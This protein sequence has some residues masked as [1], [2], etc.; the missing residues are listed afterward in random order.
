MRYTAAEKQEIIRLVEQSALS[1]RRTLA[2]MGIP[3]S[4]FYAW[5]DRYREGGAPALEDG[6]PA[7]QRVWNKLPGSVS[8]AIVD[9]ALAEPE[10][11]PGSWQ[12]PLSMSRSISSRKLRCIGC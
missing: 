8:E 11:S 7:P 6:H 4:T 10:L 2:Q 5:Y 12:R 1:V 3:R 9:L